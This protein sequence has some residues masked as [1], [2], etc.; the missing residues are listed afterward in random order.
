MQEHPSIELYVN[1]SDEQ[2]NTHVE[3][4]LATIDLDSVVANT[5]Q[6]AGITQQVML[7]LLITNDEGIR[8]M[9]KQYRE[10]DKSTDVLSFPLLEQPIV[11]APEDQLW[12]PRVDEDDT[13]LPP[14][15]ETNTTFITPPGMITNLGD[16][17]I[18]WPTILRQAQQAGHANTTELIYLLSHGILHLIG[19]DDHTESGYQ[20]MVG[21]QQAVLQKMGQKAYRG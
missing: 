13:S 18:S 11:Q 12:P 20:A 4:V 9:N 3:Q 5:L 15:S 21:I 1:L 2:Q 16:I 19:Y 10:Q 8:D 7:T 17:I 6:N 14:S